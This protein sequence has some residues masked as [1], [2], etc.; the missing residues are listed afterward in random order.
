[1][2]RLVLRKGALVH[3]AGSRRVMWPIWLL[4]REAG[5]GGVS[6]H[7]ASHRLTGQLRCRKTGSS[8]FLR[9]LNWVKSVCLRAIYCFQ[10]GKNATNKRGIIRSPGDDCKER[11][12]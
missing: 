10:S 7:D 3:L 2:Y 6:E 4:V 1:M 9:L 12:A 8:R 11:E 5:G